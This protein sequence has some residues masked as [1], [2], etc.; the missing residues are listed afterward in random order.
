MEGI[1][2]KQQTLACAY[3]LQNPPTRI[4]WSDARLPQFPGPDTVKPSCRILRSWVTSLVMPSSQNL[5]TGASCEQKIVNHQL[6][7]PGLF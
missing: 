1:A 5:A 7:W 2:Q 6:A 4:A 3:I